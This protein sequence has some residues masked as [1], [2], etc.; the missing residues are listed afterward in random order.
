MRVRNKCKICF[1]KLSLVFN[2][3]TQPLANNLN[4]TSNQ[5]SRKYPL[6]LH[7]CNNCF[8][9]QHKTEVSIKK[10]YSKYYYS[11]SVS[12]GI[13]DNAKEIA[14]EIKKKFNRNTKILEIGS[15]DGYLLNLLKKKYFCVGI[16]PS[17]NMCK[18]AKKK[19]LKIENKFF[20][21]TS[22]EYLLKK[23]GRFDIVIANNVLAHNP[24]INE[25]IS[26]IK[27]NLSKN[28][29]LIVELQDSST[30]LNKALF[31]MI[32]HEHFFYFNKLSFLN[33][34]SLNNFICTKVKNIKMHGGSMR[35]YAEHSKKSPKI[36]YDKKIKGKIKKFREISIIRDIKVKKFFKEN[37]NKK[38]YIYGAAAKTTVFLNY[39]KINEKIVKYVIDDT[40]LKQKK[41]IPNTKIKIM[42]ESIITKDKPD[43]II[44]GA[45]NYFDFIKKKLRYVKRWNGKIVTFFPDYK[46]IK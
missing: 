30:L 13:L 18:I 17:T 9:L 20:N 38:I 22:S 16:D 39:Y 15:N 21:K 43:Y 32:Y 33:L 35:V 40:I 24:N 41:Y 12:K 7:V 44:I 25:I 14:E 45:W 8:T 28:G 6:A 37:K 19:G 2:L 36:T 27:K 34:L 10:L 11:S 26:S 4:I 42:K 29:K 5:M 31:D 23:Y 3:G 1:K 46:L